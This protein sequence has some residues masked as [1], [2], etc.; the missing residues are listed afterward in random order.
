MAKR[1]HLPVHMGAEEFSQLLAPLHAL[2][3]RYCL[4]WGSGGSPR[5]VLEQCPFIQRYVSIEHEQS[6]YER[7]RAQ[8]T[9]PRL[10]LHLAPPAVPLPP[11]S[12]LTSRR[13]RWDAHA[14]L[15]RSALQ[16]YIDLPA[17]LGVCFDFVLIDGRARRFCLSAGWRLLRPGGLLVLHDAQRP[18][19]R[20]VLCSL[21]RPAFLEPWHQGQIALLRKPESSGES[22]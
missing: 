20:D 6:W 8:V 16:R 18:Q 14:E 13:R 2:G 9:D 1:G 11:R 19:Y 12:R 4:E 5:A 22:T 21:G 7:V 10:E 3:P 15:D 17:G